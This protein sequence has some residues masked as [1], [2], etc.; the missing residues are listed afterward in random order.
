M[1]K[2]LVEFPLIIT[3]S[4]MKTNLLFSFALNL[5]AAVEIINCAICISLRQ[6]KGVKKQWISERSNEI[7]TPH[8]VS[9][10]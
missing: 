2:A 10:E 3:Q 5:G 4:T 1:H 9:A 8:D 6:P 7:T